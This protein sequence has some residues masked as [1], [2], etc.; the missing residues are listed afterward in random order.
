LRLIETL[1]FF[2]AEFDGNVFQAVTPRDLEVL[3]L[4]KRVES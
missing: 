2:V 4:A 1:K 3:E